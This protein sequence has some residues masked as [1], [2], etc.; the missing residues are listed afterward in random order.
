MNVLV[1]YAHPNPHSF[2]H[3]VLEHLTKGLDDSPHT[4][5]VNDLYASGFDPVFTRLDSIQFMHDSLP[6]DLLEEA[7][8]RK[9]VLAAARGPIRRFMARRWVRDK[10]N[11][12]I[13]QALAK[14]LPKDVRAQQA[15]V[16]D[17]E[18]LIFVAPV[19]WMGFPAILKGW[20]DRVFGYGFAYALTR[21]GWRGD[22]NG[23][24]PLLSQEKAL[25]ITPTFFRE[26]D[27]DKGWRD[28][29]DTVLCDWGLT[30]PGVKDAYHVYFHAVIAADN[31]RRRA[32]LDEAYRL[33]RD[34]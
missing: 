30:M 15:L 34:F 19:F 1:T 20:F 26:D 22:L 11:R 29:M 18:G 2:T 4:Y 8:P 32:Y 12:E 10:S 28:A 13:A 3:A 33:G 9:A 5:R 14:R 7:N 25:I 31:E 21:E 27:Y 17:A 24:V 16:A 23:R 6:D